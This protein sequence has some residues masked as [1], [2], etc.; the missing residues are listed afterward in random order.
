MNKLF[1]ILLVT[2]V[3]VS[4][5]VSSK[6]FVNFSEGPALAARVDSIRNSAPIRL[7]T[8]DLLS[9][10]VYNSNELDPKVTAP[11][12]L[13]A[14][15]SGTGSGGDP[16]AVNYRVDESGN[17]NFPVLGPVKV[18]GLT[19][20]ETR[21][22]LIQKLKKYLNDPIV[23]LRLLN[24]KITVL[25]EVGHP[26]SYTV[27]TERINALEAIGMAGDLTVYSRRDSVLIIREQNG[28]REYQYLNLLSREVFSA[29]S[30]YLRQNDI[31]YVEP[32]EQKS[33]AVRDKSQRV[34]PWVT[35]GV[36]LVNLIIILARL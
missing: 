35:S 13:A 28:I 7:Q 14:A 29:P 32:I 8:D 1:F 21:E 10:V 26:G 4:S 18:A 6:E 2:L 25:G 9:I 33:L 31:V 3:G 5:C 30:F 20:A 19:P 27:P 15:V 12:N 16:T 17:I 34:L 11:F 22:V 36:T 23:N 24:F